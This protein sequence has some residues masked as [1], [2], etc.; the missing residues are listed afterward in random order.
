[1]TPVAG[2]CCVFALSSA[3]ALAD[4]TLALQDLLQDHAVLQ[5]ER[6]IKVSGRAAPA[7]QITASFA[8][9]SATAVAA[10]TGHWSLT[11]A[12]LSAG[13]P[14][15]LEVK[16]ATGQS[17]IVS[18]ILV[19]DVWLC[20]GQSNMQ[21]QVLRTASSYG[22][23]ANSANDSIRMTTIALATSETPLE[24]FK[25]PLTWLRAE[26]KTVPDFSATC[27]YFARELQ[28]TVHVPMGLI[29]SAWGGSKIEPWMSQAA[30]HSVG[31]YEK[32]LAL[33]KTYSSDRV[34][35]SRQWGERWEAWWR[36]R[37]PGSKGQE[38]W[39][40]LVAMPVW[41]TAPAALG[42]WETWGDPALQTYDGLLWYRTAVNLTARQAKQT[43]VLSIGPV[44]EIDET[45]LNGRHVGND[46]GPGKD[47]HYEIPAG[48]LHKGSNTIV[49]A[50][51]DTYGAGGLYG[52]KEKRNLK[53]AD[54]T[55]VPLNGRWEYQLP[56]AGI[57]SPPRAPW[58]DVAG[59]TLIR[60]A[61]IAPIGAYD[62]RGVLWYQGES[63]TGAPQNYQQLLG[64]FMADWRAQF[65]ADLPFLIVQLAN[66]GNAPSTTGE[67]GWADL[68][69]AQRLAVNGDSHAGLAVTIDIGDRYDIHPTNKQEL[70]RR[71]ARAARKV[72]YGE[73]IAPTGPAIVDARLQGETVTLRFK[74]VATELLAYSSNE[75]I[76]FELCRP[77]KNSCRYAAATIQGDR[78]MLDAAGSP[79]PARVRYCWADSPVCTLFDR[80]HLPA[81]PFEIALQK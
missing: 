51:L 18:D 62:L 19:G 17:Q 35:A 11:F 39:R 59:L 64:A 34:E 60:N 63:N 58:E 30:L 32:P 46:S 3:P 8:G 9:Q 12:A 48:V 29:T 70:G 37:V 24:S 72:V 52:P 25:T 81:G 21:M 61:M 45:W 40:E 78:V 57:D 27:F 4:T 69:E 75:P 10:A 26:P 80:D 65:R 73:N 77:E 68:R 28:K 33:L 66:Y 67:S 31:G 50:A 43:A 1:M 54:G 23:I 56:P 49:V 38:P 42:A 6:P 79:I 76:G 14:Y 41:R 13:G 15:S 22:E 74:D 53:L 55:V 2:W 5:R 47:R 36:E 20:S 71:L 44:D 16:S 7:E